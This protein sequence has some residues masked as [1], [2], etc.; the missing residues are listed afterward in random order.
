[1]LSNSALLLR[2]YI[3]IIDCVRGECYK[4]VAIGEA[5]RKE[6]LVTGELIELDDLTWDIVCFR[7]LI[8]AFLTFSFFLQTRIICCY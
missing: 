2:G 8:V 7:T 4:A 3:D 6:K 1:M 5:A